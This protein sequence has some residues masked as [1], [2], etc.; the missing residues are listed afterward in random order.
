MNRVS[1][2]EAGLAMGRAQMLGVRRDPAGVEELARAITHLKSLGMEEEAYELENLG[3]YITAPA[4][5]G[6]INSIQAQVKFPDQHA[7]DAGVS[8]GNAYESAW[9][10]HRSDVQRVVIR[11][12]AAL[13]HLALLSPDEEA[14]IIE[15]ADTII[16]PLREILKGDVQAAKQLPRHKPRI[17]SL[18]G[19]L[20]HFIH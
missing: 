18:Q 4:V 19:S 13:Q 14:E 2:F 7:F 8:L 6:H 5:S 11:L 9:G 16:E 17:G 15:Q 12:Q 1:L 10:T 3:S 20:V